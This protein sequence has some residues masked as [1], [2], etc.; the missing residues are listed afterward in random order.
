MVIYING[1]IIS[2]S[3]ATPSRDGNC[4]F[5]EVLM[6]HEWNHQNPAFNK[7]ITFSVKSTAE[8]KRISGF[9]LTPGEEVEVALDINARATESGRYFNNVSCFNVE[10]DKSKWHRYERA[11]RHA[12]TPEA[13]AGYA[14]NWS[15]GQTA[16]APA[17][18]VPSAPAQASQ[19][20]APATGYAAPANTQP[21]Y[22]APAAPAAPAEEPENLPF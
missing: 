9:H 21:A 3:Q 5:Q 4:Y 19:P 13:F 16:A 14:Q 20:V 1:V 18:S 2:A 17:S 11:Q 12:V 8:N 10:R 6:Q 7:Y 22:T 15:Q